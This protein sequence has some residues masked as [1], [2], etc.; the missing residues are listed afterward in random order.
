MSIEYRN[1]HLFVE[2]LSCQD[3][4]K[5]YGT[6]LYVYSRAHLER[7]WQAID[8]ALAAIDHKICYAVKANSN[9]AVLSVLVKLGSYFDVV[10]IGE[11]ERVLRAGGRADRIVFS[12]VGKTTAELNAALKLGIHCFNVESAAELER[13]AAI[14]ATL[15]LIAPVSVRVN[16]DVDAKTHPYISTGLKDNK[17]GIIWDE[18]ESVYQQAAQHESLKIVGIDCHIGSQLTEVSPF[19]D[20]IDKLLEVIGRLSKQGISFQHIDL[21]GGFGVTYRDEPTFDLQ[22]YADAVVEKIGP[23]GLSVMVEPGRYI[24]ANAGLMLVEVQYLKHSEHKNFCIVDGSMSELIRPALYSAW[25]R[26]DA[27]E[28][29][30]DTPSD[31]YDVVGPVCESSDFLGKDR[32]LAVK[33]GDIL[34][35]QSSGAYGFGMASNYNTRCR[36]A[37]LLIDG[38]K[39][40]VARR[41]ESLDDVL[42]LEAPL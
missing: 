9:L 11:I 39:V 16:P 3:L 41:R 5:K 12:G 23:L 25:Q 7:Q 35:V 32:T 20:A 28:L 15:G 21:G 36:P 14:A 31:V 42:A 1:D 13:L 30:S 22:G 33:Q 27:V 38:D 6:P 29:S 34:A 26:I 17:F 18:I 2:D 40:H 8:Q 37:E 4:A 19:N 24:A 10:S